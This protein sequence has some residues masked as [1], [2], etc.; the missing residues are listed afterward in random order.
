M[1]D[2]LQQTIA[3][4][5]N[6]AS[7]ASFATDNSVCETCGS[8]VEYRLFIFVYLGQDWEVCIPVCANC[9][10]STPMLTYEA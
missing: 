10:P 7:S 1:A 4:F 9:Q 8:V 3:G 6:S 5:L 2:T